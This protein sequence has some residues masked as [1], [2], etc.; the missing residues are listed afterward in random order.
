M[1]ASPSTI[2][3]RRPTA[4]SRAARAPWLRRFGT[5]SLPLLA[6][7]FV[8]R[9]AG[10]PQQGPTVPVEGKRPVVLREIPLDAEAQ[11]VLHLSFLI[12]DPMREERSQADC[13]VASVLGFTTV[14]DRVQYDLAHSCPVLPLEGA[15]PIELLVGFEHEGQAADFRVELT[16]ASSWKAL[17]DVDDLQ[18][19]TTRL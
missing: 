1:S 3:S 14:D 2:P 19:R 10:L 17:F 4:D 7:L 11:A 9:A 6:V 8:T 18:V 15:A 13:R 5:A 12:T 16:P